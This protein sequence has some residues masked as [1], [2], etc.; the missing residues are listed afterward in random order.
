[1]IITKITGGLGN[2]MFQYAFGRAR[3]LQWNIPFKMDR[4]ELESGRL[5]TPRQYELHHF[6]VVES[7]A[8]PEE[9][10]QLK[11]DIYGR[12]MNRI[13]LNVKNTFPDIKPSHIREHAS[14]EKNLKPGQPRSLYL[15]GYWQSE[16][17]FKAYAEVIKKDFTLRD[18]PDSWNEELLQRIRKGAS[19]SIHV[20]R[21]DYV[22]NA[23]TNK[24][25]GT[26]SLE[27]YQQAIALIE[28]EVSEPEYYVFS[29]DLPWVKE[30]LSFGKGTV[31]FVDHNSNAAHMDIM[32]MSQCKHNI[33][34]NSSFSWWGAWLNANPRKQVIAPKKWF[35]HKEDINI[36]PEP[37]IKL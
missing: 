19:V 15:D 17:Y 11:L 34:A 13:L 18:K 27:Y 1:M 5:N 31:V 14:I 2:Q 10:R 4:S 30:N 3:A 12:V 36:L 33:I 29:D 26:C 20:R 8:R 37:W 35:N 7:F 32:L 22:T 16:K 24:Y 21:G 25:H 23:S 6:N 28:K 9:L